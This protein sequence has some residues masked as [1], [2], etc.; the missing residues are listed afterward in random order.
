METS[1]KRQRGHPRSLSLNIINTLLHPKFE[2]RASAQE[3]P[4]TNH[5]GLV[6]G[7]AGSQEPKPAWRMMKSFSLRLRRR[8]ADSNGG[9]ISQQSELEQDANYDSSSHLIKR[10]PKPRIELLFPHEESD[11]SFLALDGPCEERGAEG[12]ILALA[13]NRTPRVARRTQSNNSWRVNRPV[14][15]SPSPSESVDTLKRMVSVS[16]LAWGQMSINRD[17]ERSP[18]YVVERVSLEDP[19]VL[20]EEASTPSLQPVSSKVN[21]IERKPVGSPA[22]YKT[23]S[24]ETTIIDATLQSG[25]S[26]KSPAFEISAQN[27]RNG[28]DFTASATLNPPPIS[29]SFRR[30][31]SLGTGRNSPRISPV[32]NGIPPSSGLRNPRKASLLHQEQYNDGISPAQSPGILPSNPHNKTIMPTRSH[33]G[34]AQLEDSEELPTTSSSRL[35][36]R[37]SIPVLTATPRV[38]EEALKPSHS[39]SQISPLLIRNKQQK[40][41]IPLYT[42]VSRKKSLDRKRASIQAISNPKIER[43]PEAPNYP[44]LNSK[45]KPKNQHLPAPPAYPI[46]SQP[47]KR[48]GIS[49]P[50]QIANYLKSGIRRAGTSTSP[51]RKQDEN[52]DI[53][54]N[55]IKAPDENQIASIAA[56]RALSAQPLLPPPL[57]PMPGMAELS[58]GGEVPTVSKDGK[59][60]GSEVTAKKGEKGAGEPLKS[61]MKPAVNGKSSKVSNINKSVGENPAS[62]KQLAVPKTSRSLELV[63][64]VYIYLLTMAEHIHMVLNPTSPLNSKVLCQTNKTAEHYILLAKAWGLAIVYIAV[65]LWTALVLRRFGTVLGVMGSCLLDVASVLKEAGRMVAG[66]I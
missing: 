49:P 32:P 19:F 3:I 4:A 53:N 38:H 64:L 16:D 44:I 34:P 52:D 2:K 1:S 48:K 54:C 24:G 28:V 23:S 26:P 20:P 46:L 25:F 9:S 41:P 8:R 37:S 13:K 43:M 61:A 36:P 59:K 63:K 66:G 35:A 7:Q 55:H 15:Y 57:I 42:P 6:L 51:T 10:Q 40:S 58:V 18:V 31:A 50:R 60:P 12:A 29:V 30:D 45:H 27:T 14:T 65:L 22:R 56:A 21:R 62:E 5:V 47:S 33:I 39:N 17:L 11:F